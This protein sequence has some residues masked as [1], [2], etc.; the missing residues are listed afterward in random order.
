MRTVF[1]S[2]TSK[3]LTPCRD[4]AYHAIEGL[5]GYHGVRMEDFGSWDEAPDDFCRAKVGECDMVVCIAGPCYGSLAPAGQSF[6]EREFEAAVDTKKPC[7]VFLTSDDYPLPAN[8]IESDEQRERQLTFRQKITKGR[9]ITRFATPEQVS[10]KVVQ[11]I[12]N[13]EASQ[14]AP[15]P[16]QASLLAS[17]IERVSYRVAVLNLSSQVSPEEVRKVVAS[18]QKQL[19]RDFAPAWGIDAELTFVPQGE[20]PE[21]GSWWLVIEDEGQYPGVLGYHYVTKEG[22]PEV[23]ISVS[24]AK[25]GFLSWTMAASHDLMEMLVNPQLNLTVFVPESNMTS[26][27]LYGREICDPVSHATMAYLIDGVVVSNFVYPAWFEAFR[28]PGSVQFDH[29]SRLSAPFECGPNCYMSIFDV[30]GSGWRHFF[31]PPKPAPAQSQ[32][33]SPGKA[34]SKSAKKGK[35]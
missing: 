28:K 9:M 35:S 13:W 34:K 6:T 4:A 10:V 21:P 20:E 3:D 31:G 22:L 14:A 18:L 17:Q 27:R 30:Q 26:G 12:R 7:L 19:D 25:A 33:R 24:A 5:S 29:G 1:L 8:L 15:V 32:E 23:R 2:S 11:A 16:T